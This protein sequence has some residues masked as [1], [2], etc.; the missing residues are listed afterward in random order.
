MTSSEALVAL[1]AIG[2]VVIVGVLIV[3]IFFAIFLWQVSS[4]LLARVNHWRQANGKSPLGSGLCFVL[5]LAVLI[6]LCVT[7]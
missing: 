1:G 4:Y 5:K 3:Y 7:G 2:A 6:V